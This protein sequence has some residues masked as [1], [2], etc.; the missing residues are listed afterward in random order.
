MPTIGLEDRK[1]EEFDGGGGQGYFLHIQFYE[2]NVENWKFILVHT[3]QK[4]WHH[5]VLCAVERIETELT[6]IK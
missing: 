4:K 6:R 1:V 2:T 5:V 3:R